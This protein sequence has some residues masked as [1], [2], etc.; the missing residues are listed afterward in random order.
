MMNIICKE[1]G[2]INDYRTEKKA[3]NL[4]AHCNGCGSY[5]KNLPYAKPALHFG[6]YKGIPIEEFNTPERLNYL[7]WMI[8]SG[9]YHKQSANVRRAIDFQINGK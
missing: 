5:I 4:V 9:V 6:K 1:C 7:H 3:N 2:C 8:N